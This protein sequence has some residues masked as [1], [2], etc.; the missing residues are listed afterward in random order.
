MILFVVV[1][2][3]KKNIIHVSQV[4]QSGSVTGFVTAEKIVIE[5][6]NKKSLLRLFCLVLHWCAEY[7]VS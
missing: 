3:K 5:K 2:S 4:H 7:D 1:L 6:C